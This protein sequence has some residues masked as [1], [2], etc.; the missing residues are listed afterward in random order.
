[1]SVALGVSM[2]SPFLQFF[3]L[4][5]ETVQTMC[6]FC[7]YILF[8]EVLWTNQTFTV[9]NSNAKSLEKFI[10]KFCFLLDSVVMLTII[11]TWVSVLA[12]S[13]LTNFSHFET[14]YFL[15]LCKLKIKSLV[16]QFSKRFYASHKISLIQFYK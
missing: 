14:G 12:P 8:E 5:F 1:M 9:S 16:Y 3:Q 7:F 15:M 11:E 13:R 6:H 2:L 10:I 4:D